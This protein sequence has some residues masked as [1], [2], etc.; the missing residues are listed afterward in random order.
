MLAGL[1]FLYDSEQR[2]K[3]VYWIKWAVLAAAIVFFALMFPAISGVPMPR[4]YAWFL[5]RVL[6]TGNLM[7]DRF[8]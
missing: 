4:W 3:K 2:S 5:E 1:Y 8:F 6:P 7:Y